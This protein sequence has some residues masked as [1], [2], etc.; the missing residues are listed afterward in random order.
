MPEIARIGEP[1]RFVAPRFEH[2]AGVNRW[3]G[4][5]VGAE[6][7]PGDGKAGDH[8]ERRRAEHGDPPIG[9]AERAEQVR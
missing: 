8:R 4:G 2:Q 3:R 6:L 9:I 7:R 5:K 1:E